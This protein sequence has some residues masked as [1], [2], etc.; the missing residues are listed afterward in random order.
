MILDYLAQSLVYNGFCRDSQ[1]NKD[2]IDF[3]SV[4]D[5][6]TC[7]QTCKD[8][9]GC[10]AF[11]FNSKTLVGLS[12][13]N[14]YR[15]G[16]YIQGTGDSHVLCYVFEGIKLEFFLKIIISPTSFMGILVKFL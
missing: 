2:I 10:A 9:F 14:L 11:A 6:S 7:N 15:Q 16:P 1:N 13:C 4:T 12:N 8:T 5:V 3:L